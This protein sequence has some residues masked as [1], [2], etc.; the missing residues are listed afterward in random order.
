V[1]EKLKRGNVQRQKKGVSG[2]EAVA[3]NSPGN[4]MEEDEELLTLIYKWSSKVFGY[5]FVGGGGL[6]SLTKEE[7]RQIPVHRTPSPRT[8]L[9]RSV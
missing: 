8:V 5:F 9:E 3:R 4:K 1:R 7:R 6:S 2:S